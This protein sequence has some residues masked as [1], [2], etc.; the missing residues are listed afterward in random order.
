[1]KKILILL[2]I[3]G[4]GAF[5]RLYNLSAF[6]SGLNAD[7][8]ALGYNAYSLLQTGKDEHGHAWPINFESFGDYKPALYGYVLMP[9]IKIFGLSVLAVRLPSALL[10]ILAVGLIF[11]LAKQAFSEPV[12]YVA[13]AYLAISPWHI[14]FSRGGWEVNMATTLVMLGVWL[15]CKW[16][17][18]FKPLYLIFSVLCLVLSMYTYQS[19]RLL[20]PILGIGLL[21]VFAKDLLAKRNQ[22]LA[23]GLIGIGVLVPL[24][25]SFIFSNAIS[26]ASGVG[27]F[28]D[29]GPVNRVNQ[30]RG[31]Y[32]NPN[33]LLAKVM[34]NKII[35]YT[36]AFVENYTD[37]FSGNFLFINGDAIERN[38]VP[39][40]GLLYWTDLIFIFL[41]GY[42]LVNSKSKW[43]KFIGWWLFSAPLA[44]ALTFQTPHALRA[45]IMVIPLAI[46]I[47]LGIWQVW[48][49]FN[50]KMVM[51]LIAMVYVWQCSRY[52]HEYYIHY[53]QEYPAAWEYGFSQVVDY[54]Q[55]HKND[56]NQILVT[57]KYD[58]PY[59]L[60]LFFSHYPP[61]SF[62]FHH[63]LTVRD[64]FNFSTV[65]SYDKYVFTDTSWEK[66]RDIHNAL[67]I[68][69]PEDIPAV[70]ANVV[71]T[72]NFPG[73]KPAFKIVAN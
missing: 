68:A 14:H 41:G 61:E 21:V 48:R 26:R 65:N 44:A 31:Q 51:L 58:Q 39:E 11:A 64:R 7:E 57:T 13:A 24:I 3:L 8:A 45:Q 69:A 36:F 34:Q 50:F 71:K 32:P 70:G 5:L 10:G 66:V 38:K 46:I 19:A 59:I 1:M 35:S 9:F 54:V 29:I 15:F 27:L 28:A 42:F 49:R 2:T 16:Q 72:I 52:L 6:P 63:Q 60:F 53:P 20:A 4:V 12:G 56:Y 47:G 22:A 73:G 23:A 25:S 67:I 17:K 55:M 43:S 62:Q 40:T 30:L 18:G 33:G 37:H